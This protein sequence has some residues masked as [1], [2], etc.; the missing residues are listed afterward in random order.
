MENVGAVD[1]CVS[2]TATE[3]NCSKL[4]GRVMVQH[5]YRQRHAVILEMW[6]FSSKFRS[7]LDGDGQL[8]IVMMLIMEVECAI[9]D[10]D[11]PPPAT[12]VQIT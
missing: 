2:V 6:Q 12:A 11:H 10:I 8:L 9:S 3:D 4:N 7:K 5:H 1:I